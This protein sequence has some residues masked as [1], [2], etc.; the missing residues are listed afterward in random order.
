V[1]EI[2]VHEGTGILVPPCDVSAMAKAIERLLEDESLR[3]KMGLE[4]RRRV[5]TTFTA[6][7]TAREVEGVYEDILEDAS[8]Y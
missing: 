3:R 6:E 8:L 7:G 4:G 5:E 1:P 2:V